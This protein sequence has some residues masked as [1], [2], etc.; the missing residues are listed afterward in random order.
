ML[1]DTL[2]AFI[3]YSKIGSLFHLFSLGVAVD[4]TVLHILSSLSKYVQTKFDESQI[5]TLPSDQA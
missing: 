3:L 2:M 5:K 4:F 1:M